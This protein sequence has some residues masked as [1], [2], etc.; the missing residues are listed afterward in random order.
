MEKYIQKA[1]KTLREDPKDADSLFLFAE[2]NSID[3]TVLVYFFHTTRTHVRLLTIRVWKKTKKSKKCWA[4]SCS[5]KGS[6]IGYETSNLRTCWI[7]LHS[8]SNH[9]T[10]HTKHRIDCTNDNI[11]S[12][13]EI[14]SYFATGKIHCLSCMVPLDIEFEP[15]VNRKTIEV[16]SLWT[17]ED[18]YI[19]WIPEEVLVDILLLL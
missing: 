17:L 7:H 13:I 6:L 18:S 11:F 1:W 15:N 9:I 16:W 10:D 8:Y 2:E 12:D 4:F 3:A 5:L 19:Q 14:F